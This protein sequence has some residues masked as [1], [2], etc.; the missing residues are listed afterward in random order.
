MLG[1]QIATPAAR[2]LAA[3]IAA[4]H[5]GMVMHLRA[6]KRGA[7]CTEDCPH[8][9]ARVLWPMAVEAFGADADAL[10]FL[11]T[12]GARAEGRTMDARVSRLG[13]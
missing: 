9:E 8:E 11:E 6:V 2:D 13:P 3:Q 1:E 5:D 4:W 12:H 10:S 7:V